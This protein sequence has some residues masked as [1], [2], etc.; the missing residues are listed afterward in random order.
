[1][2]KGLGRLQQELIKISTATTTLWD[3][4]PDGLQVK[5]ADTCEKTAGGVTTEEATG[6]VWKRTREPW[7]WAR[8]VATSHEHL[9]ELQAAFRSVQVE[10]YNPADTVLTACWS[11]HHI[12]ATLW[13]DLW[14]DGDMREPMPH[15][16]FQYATLPQMP[17]RIKRERN[18]A[19]AGLSRA[20]L[21][22]EK[23]GMVLYAGM[24]HSALANEMWKRYGVW[25]KSHILW[26]ILDSRL[27]K[28]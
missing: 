15:P 25:S 5:V 28:P 21:S 3:V 17:E 11:M 19:Q 18:A 22:L 14:I 1:M 12:R 27:L 10:N 23:R 9:I 16:R 20:M 26:Y 24:T 2:S 13:P 7:W 8:T 4:M 6:S